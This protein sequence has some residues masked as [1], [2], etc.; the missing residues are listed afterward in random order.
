[1]DEKAY[2]RRN[3]IKNIAIIFLAL[4]LVLTL[5]S[6]TILNYSLPQVAAQYCYSGT[7][8]TRIKG[9][10]TVEAKQTYAVTL[11]ASAKIKDIGVKVGS[12]VEAGDIMF[13]LEE[14]ESDDLLT[15]VTTLTDLKK[16]YNDALADL[17]PD[18][19]AL[20]QEIANLSAD[21]A[22]LRKK[23]SQA[24]S[25]STILADA[26]EQK[27]EVD[28]QL[29]TLSTSLS[30]LDSKIA[31]LSAIEGIEDMSIPAS[32][33]ET[34]K[35]L[36]E[37]T[38]ANVKAAKEA[39]KTAESAL[40]AA[41]KALEDAQNGNSN[42]S[43]ESL[44]SQ[45]RALDKMKLEYARTEEDYQEEYSNLSSE[46]GE[47]YLKVQTTY[48]AWQ[49]DITNTEL[50]EAYQAAQDAL[51]AKQKSIND[52][53]KSTQ[54]SLEDQSIAIRNAEADL[55]AAQASY[56][57]SN[58]GDIAM[59]EQ[60]VE[61]AQTA[62]E[63]AQTSQSDCELRQ[64]DSELAY[65]AAQLA[66]YQDEYSTLETQQ[67]A[68]EKQQEQLQETIDE[69]SS[70]GDADD[71][72]KQITEKQQ[73]LTVKNNELKQT[74]KNDANLS[75]AVK[76]RIEVL[77]EKIKTQEE[78]IEKMQGDETGTQLTAPVAGIVTSIKGSIGES[79]TMGDTIA[80]IQLVDKGCSLSFTVTNDQAK[81]LKVGDEASITNYWSSDNIVAKIESITTD[82][83][84]PRN[85]KKITLNVTG[86]AT[87]GSNLSFT[88]GEK[89]Q[90][91]DMVV[92]NSAIR[93]DNA[94]K[95][96]LIVEAS[97]TP[98]G[99]RY[100]AVRADVSVVASDDKNTAVSG[101][102]YG[103]YVITTS[104][105]PLTSGTQVRMSES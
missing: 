94:G 63:N 93:E 74:K 89:S 34:Y 1:M 52:Q 4:M 79:L 103:Q 97:S 82:Q 51:D 28:R 42:V 24:S 22:E 35:E 17:S 25:G 32:E 72:Q 21:I 95:F 18:Y 47:Y 11:P 9:S 16:Q 92:P 27:K 78:K 90:S 31:T 104:S 57:A 65:N 7:I 14:S 50:Y 87:V 101:L 81:R 19:T 49:N 71:I 13:L 100:T 53:L 56:D 58:S 98:F 62:L 44:V 61:T 37:E 77:E 20:N 46:L 67:T 15:A 38:K 43:Y 12:S 45:Q 66:Q 33:L 5:F 105:K 83:N 59:L 26:K 8:T 29:K 55:A 96:V 54:R 64:S 86:D 85:S 102:D 76:I 40:N 23:L 2:K 80:E 88:L 41:K 10:G 3:W 39:V 36:L 69:Y 91:Y 75:D 60:N 6:Q 30:K 70:T 99:N 84:D 68:L 73:Q 48:A